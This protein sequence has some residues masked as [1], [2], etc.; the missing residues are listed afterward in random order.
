MSAIG[1]DLGTTYSCVGIWKNGRVEILANDQ[2]N[3]TTPSYVAFTES[4]RLIG[5]A[6]KNQAALN[7]KNT[8]YDA[9]RLIGRR[10]DDT[11]VQADMKLWPFTVVKNSQNQPEIQVEHKEETKQFK[12]EE[13]SAMVLTKMKETAEAALGHE[14]KDAVITVP[15]YFNDAQRQSTRDAGTIAGLNVL[16][17]I[18]EPTAAAMAYGLDKKGDKEKNIL[19]FDCGGGTHDCSI[20][21][22]D[23]GIY[24]VKATCFDPETPV[25]MA[26]GS[27]KQIK[28]IEV[29]EYVCGD[30]KK[31]RKVTGKI[32]GKDKMYKIK[33][34]KSNAIDYTVNSQHTLVLKAIGV[35][36]YITSRT[37]PN[38]GTTSFRLMYYA[39]CK[40]N[41]LKSTCSKAG[42]KKKEKSYNSMEDA[43]KDMEMLLKKELDSSVVLEGDIFEITVQ[44]FLNM[45]SSDTQNSRLKGYKVPRPVYNEYQDDLPLDPYFVGLWLGDGS[46]DDVIIYSSDQEIETYLNEYAET[47]GNMMTIKTERFQAGTISSTGIESNIEYCRHRFVFNDD[48]LNPVRQGLKQLKLLGNKHIPEIYM[49]SSEENRFKLLAGLLDSDG[50]LNYR[51]NSDKTGGSWR[52]SFRQSEKRKK[53]VYQ[54]KKLANTLGFYG[55]RIDQIE[56]SPTGRTLYRDGKSIHMHYDL[57]FFGPK[58]LDVPC[59]VERKKASVRCL[60]HN[61]FNSSVS[62][63]KINLVEDKEDF[64]GISV[65][66][67]QR[68]LLADCTVVHNCGD[69]HLGGEDFDNRMVSHFIKEFQRKYKKDF[70]ANQ[71]SVKRLKVACER[72]KR[73]LSTRTNASI[74]I[75]SLYEGTDF[76]T[77]ITRAR[78]EELC[79]DLFHSAM[80]PVNQVLRDAKMSKSDIDEIVMVGG[81]TRIP[82]IQ[83]MLTDYFNGK[84][85]NHTINPD[86]AVAYGAAAQAAILTNASDAPDG[87]LLDVNPLSLGI[88][89]AG[90]VM[91]NIIERNTT[92]PCHKSQTFS[93]YADN[94]PAVTIRIF[95]GERAMT[96]DNNLLGEFTLS[97]IPPAPRG[98]PQIEVSFDL[99]TN[100][101]LNVSAVDKST[102]KSE[103]ISIT[104]DA[105]RMSKEDV[106]R[107]VAEAAKYA[108]EDKA[109]RELIDARNGL[110]SYCFTLKNS[111]NEETIKEKISETD[112]E[113]VE[114]IAK[115]TVEWL[116]SNPK[117]ELQE[118]QDKKAAVEAVAMPIMSKIYADSTGQSV[119]GGMPG[120]PP[121]SNGEENSPHI[122]EVD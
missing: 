119:P 5:D 73:S 118:Y 94:Q 19:V 37:Y 115:E 60:N 3:R 13:I 22:I 6:A 23:E 108:E 77:S 76:Y 79:S 98:I 105:G 51:K 10:F 112:R 80:E 116:E 21:T 74:E 33:Q 46:T 87:V 55:L 32:A 122:E 16:R 88:E 70:S 97:G 109:A 99:D 59:L 25:L 86:E 57:S 38:T 43:K 121:P 61:F 39:D 52:Y 71:R 50:S 100:G 58:M 64:V 114:N 34:A 102:N 14:V 26:D 120:G 1:I 35:T 49:K 42:F 93:T 95:E 48:G 44:D 69:A 29:G 75:D 110:E 7:P 47:F 8:V 62:N 103:K 40:T 20:L 11:H 117:A 107:L 45:C 12:P 91:T 2:G 67:N 84:T 28:D 27:E 24:E 31:K 85:L 90:Q 56:V 41:C 92:I 36:P 89:T 83:K 81:S 63:I 96:K 82:K 113:A 72:A 54:V 78:F 17:I 68:F 66:G 104:N 18:N 9:K 4:E 30:D 106:E 65:D 15:A 101:M 53:L 111:L